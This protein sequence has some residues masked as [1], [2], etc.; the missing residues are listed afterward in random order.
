MFDVI[1]VNSLALASVLIS[2]QGISKIL[3]L[4]VIFLSI[5]FTFYKFYI[6]NKKK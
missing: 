5:S 2:Y 4:L 6:N 3:E 1:K